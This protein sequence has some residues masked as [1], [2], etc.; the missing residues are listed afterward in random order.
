MPSYVPIIT[1][2]GTSTVIDETPVHDGQI[3]FDESRKCLFMDNG[4]TRNKYSGL[5]ADSNV[6]TVEDTTTSTHAYAKGDYVVVEGQ[7]Y[8][9]TA[10]IAVGDTF[11]VGTN[12]SVTTVGDEL[13]QI[14]SDLTNIKIGNYDVSGT[15]DSYGSLNISSGLPNNAIPILA[16]PTSYWYHFPLNI[17]K[18]QGGDFS[19]L[20]VNGNTTLYT[21]L[22]GA[23]VSAKIYYIQV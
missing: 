21:P 17:F 9:V 23:S 3:L 13:V 12:I 4:N 19:V 5:G 10:A 7:L 22:V 16:Q 14:K 11:S 18:S 6:A 2:R 20:F 8:E 15:T 1:I